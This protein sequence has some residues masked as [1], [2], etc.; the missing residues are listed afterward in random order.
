MIYIHFAERS[1]I[2]LF[3]GKKTK[4]IN[5]EPKRLS[6]AITVKH[7]SLEIETQAGN[8]DLLYIHMDVLIDKKPNFVSLNFTIG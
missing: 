2:L 1:L 3:L 4:H 8:L 5:K 6:E 7:I